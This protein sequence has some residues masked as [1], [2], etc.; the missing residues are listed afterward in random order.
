M[1]QAELYLHIP[2][3]V[4]KCEYCDF[5]SAAPKDFAETEAYLS[6]LLHEAEEKAEDLAD[7]EII[8]IFIGG[9]TPSILRPRQIQRL[10]EGLYRWYRI[11]EDAEITMECNPG[12]VD[13]EKLKIM[14]AS[15]NNRI[16]FGLQ[17]CSREELQLL[18]RIHT[19]EEFLDGYQTARQTGFSNINVDLMFGLP[20]QSLKTYKDTL[21]K[22]IALEPEHISA[23]G[24][25][26]EEGTPFYQRYEEDERA[27][28]RGEEPR[29]LPSEETERLMYLRT[30]EIL[31]HAGYQRYEISN[32][33]KKGMECRHNMGYWTGVEYLGLGLGASSMMKVHLRYRSGELTRPDPVWRF[34]TNSDLSS[35]IKGDFHAESETALSLK[36]QMEEYAFLGLRLTKGISKAE[37]GKRFHRPFDSVY[38]DTVRKAQKE[39]LLAEEGDRVRLTPAG[40]D[41]S[42]YV[43]SQFLLDS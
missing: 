30:A 2:F 13:R 31:R 9:G 39:G 41:I 43:L 14:K 22:V 36:E 25:I 26:I 6:A 19:F 32:Y 7:Y 3:C 1:K 37:F 21:Q 12:T 42:N 35:Y 29:E 33:A 20:N 38:R 10:M 8:S 11:R 40:I 17:S 18:G 34:R 15:G 28:Q 23:Y 5:L 4:R 24:L 16:S 27:R